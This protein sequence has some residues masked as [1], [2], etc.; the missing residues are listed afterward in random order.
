METDRSTPLTKKGAVPVRVLHRI[1]KMVVTPHGTRNQ[2]ENDRGKENKDSQRECGYGRSARCNE[3]NV[4]G[5]S[6]GCG[7]HRPK[8]ESEIGPLQGRLENSRQFRLLDS[9]CRR[10]AD[11]QSRP[12]LPKDES[13]EARSRF[14]AINALLVSKRYLR[15]VGTVA[16]PAVKVHAFP[17]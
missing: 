16:I 14:H 13:E 4:R 15:E 7:D 17:Q 5:E 2:H 11:R 8:N 9:A 12:S 1:N 10:S 6:D 3:N